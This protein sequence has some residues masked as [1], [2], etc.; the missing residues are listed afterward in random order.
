MPVEILHESMRRIASEDL[1]AEQ[2]GEGYG[3]PTGPTE[4][5]V[6]IAEKG[7][8]LFSDIHGDRRMRW[9]PGQGVTVDK[10]GTGKANGMTRD[11]R[12]RLISCHHFTRCVDAE[13]LET[14]EVTVIADKYRGLKLNRPND[15]V[16]KSDGAV[17]F[18][19]PP[20]RIPLTPPDHYPEQDCAGVYRVSPDGQRINRI[21]HDF[22]NP[23]GLCFS[24]DEKTLYVNDSHINRK[25]IKAYTVETNGMVD[26]G[27][28]RLF[29]DMRGD[30]RRG[31][32]DGMKCDIEGN[33]YCTGP[34]GIWVVNPAEVHIGT[35]INAN[36]PVNMNWGDDDLRTLY[37][38]GAYTINRIRLGIPGVPVPRGSIS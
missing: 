14:G 26:L 7:Y 19:D 20:P 21:V 13:D 30:D 37:F 29:C 15:V 4:G 8:L 18:T 35:I 16:V 10:Q 17:Y 22:A 2:L 25:L 3:G 31:I 36:I 28:E 32:P 33:V 38:A 34:G 23:N 27:S 5:P 6:W 24:P 9:T 1:E 12:G 11:P